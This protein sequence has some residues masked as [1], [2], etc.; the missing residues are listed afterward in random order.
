MEIKNLVFNKT[1][2]T[3][4]ILDTVDYVE[5]RGEELVPVSFG[6]CLNCRY[7]STSITCAADVTRPNCRI[8]DFGCIDYEKEI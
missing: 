5:F 7:N 8:R 2:S 3:L 4:N 1:R 6:L